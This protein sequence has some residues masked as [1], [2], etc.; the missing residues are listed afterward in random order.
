MDA[1]VKDERDTYI[2]SDSLGEENREALRERG[3]A[4]PSIDPKKS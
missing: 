3:A 1:R 2:C 4:K